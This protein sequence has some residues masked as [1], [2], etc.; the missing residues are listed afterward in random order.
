[1]LTR[2]TLLPMLAAIPLRHRSAPEM[3]PRVPDTHL[4]LGG[5]VMLSRFVGK[6]ARERGDPASP[7]RELAPVLASADIAFVNL[8]APFS[9]RGKLVESGMIFKAEPEMI[10]ALELAGIDIVSTANNHARDCGGYGV[11]FTLDW[12]AGHGI[13]AVGSAKS[14]E[15]AHAGVVLTRNGTRFGFLAYTFDQSNGNHRDVDDRIAALDVDQ[16]REDVGGMLGRTRA[17]HTVAPQAEALDA[18]APQEGGPEARADVVIVS[19]HAGVEYSPRPN[20]QQ[21]EFAQAAID[22][23]ARVVVG[24]HPHVVEPWERVGESV[25]FYSL[26]NLVFDQFQREETQHGALAELTFSGARLV[27]AEMVP[28]DIART[29][30]RLAA[31]RAGVPAQVTPGA[32]G[33]AAS[34]RANRVR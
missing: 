4:I 23:G 18:L 29:G 5:D 10:G 12:L 14:A 7:L 34:G 9:D 24:H 17:L 33:V 26:G 31:N 16:M 8:E 19:M 6:F 27:H 20:R 3:V 32:V 28:V 15:A 21:M 1:M 13:A 22:A 2:R 25:I 11:E 30:P